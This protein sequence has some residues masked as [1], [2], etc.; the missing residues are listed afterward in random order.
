MLGLVCIRFLLVHRCVTRVSHRSASLL[1][2]SRM[3]GAQCCRTMPCRSAA[4]RKRTASTSASVNSSRSK[5]RWSATRGDLRA[6]MLDVFRPHAAD[7]T[8][9]G[10]VFA[11]V[12]D[13]PECHGR[14][15]NQTCGGRAIGQTGCRSCGANDLQDGD[16]LNL[17][18]LLIRR[19]FDGTGRGDED[20]RLLYRC[21]SMPSAVIF[22]SSV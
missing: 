6:H 9:R 1:I 12:G 11:D 16:V 21:L 3:N 14:D 18:N 17:Q 10:P 7:Q 2:H 19:H 8:N 15:A 20:Q 5:R 22:E 13:D 4:T